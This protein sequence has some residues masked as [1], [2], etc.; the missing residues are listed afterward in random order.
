VLCLQAVEAD[1]TGKHAQTYYTEDACIAALHRLVAKAQHDVTHQLALR[2]VPED[3][4]LPTPKSN[5]S[6]RLK[7]TVSEI[8]MKLASW[9]VPGLVGGLGRMDC[10]SRHTHDIGRDRSLAS[11]E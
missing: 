5:R 1:S 2:R 8:S 9:D 3:S 11:A 4:A 10:G 6:D 7:L